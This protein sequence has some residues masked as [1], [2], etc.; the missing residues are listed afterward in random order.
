MPTTWRL[1]LGGKI[2]QTAKGTDTVFLDPNPVSFKSGQIT[3]EG[4]AGL[5]RHWGDRQTEFKV[6]RCDVAP[7]W[8]G[9]DRELRMIRWDGPQY[10]TFP[11]E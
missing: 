9:G 6:G 1:F 3:F 8:E 2:V 7:G 11:D 5:V 10:P 4:K